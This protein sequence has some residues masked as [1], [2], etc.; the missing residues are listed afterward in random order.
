MPGQFI[1]QLLKLQ[2]SLD[3]SSLQEQ[4]DHLAK[5]RDPRR[6][7][8]AFRTRA[9]RRCGDNFANNLLKQFRI[10]RTTHQKLIE[11]VGGIEREIAS[12]FDGG[13]QVDAVVA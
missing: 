2:S 1:P 6:S 11:R 4:S 12:F 13:G 3:L 8:L 7:P 5:N 10:R 9:V